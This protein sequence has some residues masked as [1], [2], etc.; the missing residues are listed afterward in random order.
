MR[1]TVRPAEDMILLTWTPTKDPA[2]PSEDEL[3][4]A[5]LSFAMVE[6]GGSHGALSRCGSVS[7]NRNRKK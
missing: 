2:G 5:V 1:G 6:V 4:S 3:F 7:S